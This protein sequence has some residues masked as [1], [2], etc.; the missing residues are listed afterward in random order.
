MFNAS[1]FSQFCFLSGH[2]DGHFHRVEEMSSI[3]VEIL[4]LFVSLGVDD[5]RLHLLSRGGEKEDPRNVAAVGSEGRVFRLLELRQEMCD[6][7]P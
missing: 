6:G 1:K 7:R 2:I 3:V 4:V 5:R